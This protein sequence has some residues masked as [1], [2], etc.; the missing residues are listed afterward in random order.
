MSERRNQANLSIMNQKNKL[1][2]DIVNETLNKIKSFATSSNT[3]YQYL[4]RK[5]I[6]EV[7]Y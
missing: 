5:L 3:D 6:L 4:I 2:K 7:N 1:L